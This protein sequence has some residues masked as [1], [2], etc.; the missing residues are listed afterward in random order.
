MFRRFFQWLFP[1]A[2]K[3]TAKCQLC[4]DVRCKQRMVYRFGYGW[5]CSDSEF[6]EYWDGFQW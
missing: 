5:F 3:D 2:S 1:E 4:G 6:V